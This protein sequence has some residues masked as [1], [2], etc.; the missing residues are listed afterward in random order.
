MEILTIANLADI[1]IAALLIYGLLVLIRQTNAKKIIEGMVILVIIYI[2][3]IAFNLS[4]LLTIFRFFFPILL[5]ALVIIF[6]EEFRRFFEFLGILPGR[7][8]PLKVGRIDRNP[9]L[10]EIA[11]AVEYL[12]KR[13]TGAIIVLQGNETVERHLKGGTAL[14]GKVSGELLESLFDK[15]TP[16]HDGAVIIDRDI[17]TQFGAHL[18]LS[19]KTS[20]LKGYGTR[21]AAALGLSEK[22]DAFTIVI[23]EERGSISIATNSNLKNIG[24][25]DDI[26]KLVRNFY[27]AKFPEKQLAMWENIVKR[28]S[29]D[30]IIALTTSVILWYLLTR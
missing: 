20:K 26:K 2:I 29:K 7:Y 13:K 11:Q 15:H 24:K 6:Q 1:L 17:I 5:I 19:R 8:S 9:I 4:L 27:R 18:P 25:D 16:T 3:A 22:T 28:N 30:K 21:H 23:S 10:E 14:M 12:A